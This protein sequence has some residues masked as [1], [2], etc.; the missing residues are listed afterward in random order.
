[1]E[2][3]RRDALAAL[4]AAG[5]AGGAALAV[6]GDLLDGLADDDVLGEEPDETPS[7]PLDDATLSVLVAAAE[8]LYPDAVDG[9][10]A[11]VTEFAQGRA[12]DRPDHARGVADA[13]AYLDEYAAAWF[14]DEFAALSPA[15]RD[16]ALRRMGADTADPDPEGGD[17]GRV[18]YY[19]VNDLLF[20]LYA[21][22]TGGEL[23]GIENP[24]GYPGGTRSY[25]RGPER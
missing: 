25:Q 9:V 20:A 14:D 13:A 22:P 3:S 15:D 2:L 19:V 16:A 10:E 6:D 8:V 24:Q 18:R 11:F 23:V 17:V 5:A 1:M 7:G 21:S 4:A 12:Q